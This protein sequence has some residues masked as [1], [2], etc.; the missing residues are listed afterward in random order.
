M[1]REARLKIFEFVNVNNHNNHSANI[2]PVLANFSLCQNKIP[3][4][5]CLEK[6]RTKFPVFPVPWPPWFINSEQL[7]IFGEPFV[8]LDVY[9]LL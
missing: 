7:C 9:A 4:F 2:L 8:T 3:C 5:P 1:L 6:V